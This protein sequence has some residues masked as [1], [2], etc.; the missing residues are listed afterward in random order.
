VREDHRPAHYQHCGLPFG[1][2]AAANVIGEYDEIDLPQVKPLVR[3]HRRLACRCVRCGK[4]TSV[5]VPQAPQGTPFGRRIHALAL[6][7]KTNPLFSYQRLQ[8][9][10]CDLFKLDISLGALMNSTSHEGRLLKHSSVVHEDRILVV[11]FLALPAIVEATDCLA[12]VQRRLAKRYLR[13]H[14]IA[15]HEP[16]VGQLRI[17][18]FWS[19][20]SDCDAAHSWIRDALP[21]LWRCG[22]IELKRGSPWIPARCS[23]STDASPS[24]PAGAA[25]SAR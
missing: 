2:D 9:A 1:E 24:S 3:R 13:S 10:I 6:Y 21:A 22:K 7:L 23:A 14:A 16:E 20:S 8:G 4:A 12:L 18:A 25:A 17:D 19:R 11:Q 15:L 5:P